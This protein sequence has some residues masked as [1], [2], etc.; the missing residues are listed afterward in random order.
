MTSCKE[1]PETDL[2]V[3]KVISEFKS[4]KGDSLVFSSKIN[5]WYKPGYAIEELG[6]TTISTDTN[7]HSKVI[8]SPTKYL[9]IDLKRKVFSEYDSFK[10]SAKKLKVYSQSDS[11]L[12]EGGWNF[13]WDKNVEIQG[14][15]STL[16]DTIEN[17]KL[18]ERIEFYQKGFDSTRFY[19]IGYIDCQRS[20]MFSYMKVFIPGKSNCP[21]VKLIMIEKKNNKKIMELSLIQQSNELSN[22]EQLIFSKWSKNSNL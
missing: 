6:I 17:G 12:I 22:T 9:F 16:P 4:F 18:Y 20:N 13:Y 2:H 3:G 7:R 1:N 8:Y 11:T 5:I 19:C 21:V 14:K 10:P 15:I